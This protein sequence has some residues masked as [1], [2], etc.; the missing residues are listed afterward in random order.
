MTFGA[1][2]WLWA[3]LLAPL[4]AAIFV[5]NESLREVLLRKLVSPRLLAGLSASASAPRRRWKFALAV[6]GLALAIAALAQPRAGYEVT[7]NHQ[8]GLDLLIAVDTSKSMLSADVQ[9][10]RLSRAKFAGQDLIDALEGDRVGLI[11]FAGTSFVQAPLTIDYSAVEAALSDLDTNTIPRGGTNIAAAIR[12]AADAFG[13]GESTSRALVLFTDG[14]ELEDD[15][16]QAAREAKGKFRIFTV[17]VG[18]AEGSLIPIPGTDGGTDF[19]KDDQGQFVKS[20]LDEEKLKAI[21]DATGGFYIHLDSGTAAAKTIIEQGLQKMQL[22]EFAT[23]E[24]RPIE[25]YEWPLSAGIVLLILAMAIPERRRPAR[26][27]RKAAALAGSVALALLAGPP[28]GRAENQGLQLYDQK[29]YKGAYDVFQQQLQRNPDS[30]GLEFD[31]GAAAYKAGDYDKALEA[32][33]KVIGSKDQRLRGQ[34][35]YNLGNTLVQ[36]GALQ[37]GKDEKIKEWNGA[38]G[39]Y[40]QAL[41]MNPQNAD[42][43]YNEDLV[44]RMIDDLNKK[45]PTP[46]P[47]QQQDQKQKDQKQQQNQQQQNQQQ[48]NQQQQNQQQQNQQQ[49]NQQQQNQQQQNQQQQNQQQQNQQQQNQQ[50][51]N[52]QQQNQQQQNQQQQG[53]Q[54][55]GQ[56][57]QGQQQQGQQQPGQQQPGQQNPS[58]AGQQNQDEQNQGSSNPSQEMNGQ[59]PSP[60]PTPENGPGTL[61]EQAQK[62]DQSDARTAAKAATEQAKP[63]EMTP[64]QAQ[65]LIDSLRGEDEHVNFENR[66]NDNDTPYKDW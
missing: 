8:R 39:H 27:R 60:S 22:H 31:R 55:Q 5:R 3:M 61:S 26:A 52:Q 36:R 57:Q 13:T 66:Q 46:P 37:E 62:N 1:P 49:Q 42:A 10:D 65:A 23:H 38:I 2:Q 20:H 19:V 34:A 33:G 54:Q 56:Q 48:Q 28:H 53:Q 21:A 14:E 64:S 6:A 16:V 32:F 44:Q 18:T 58:Q 12:E 35:E 43:K 29:N 63:G 51:Q 15:A 40:K 59:S 11:A 9:P 47:Q 7:V 17:G 4:L 30:D 50:Q 45:Q 25:R 24:N 41:A